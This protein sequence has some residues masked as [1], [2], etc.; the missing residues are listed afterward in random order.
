M[1]VLLRWLYGLG[2]C[3]SEKWQILEIL[4][5]KPPYQDQSLHVTDFRLF[6]LSCGL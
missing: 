4:S 5:G 2:L 1:R 3:I 6:D